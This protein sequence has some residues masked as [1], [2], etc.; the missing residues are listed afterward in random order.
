MH[1][2]GGLSPWQRG[3]ALNGS[4]RTGGQANLGVRGWTYWFEIDIGCPSS[5]IREQLDGGAGL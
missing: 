2:G 3:T 4:R 1:P 5:N